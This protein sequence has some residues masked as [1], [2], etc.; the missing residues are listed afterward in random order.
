[1]KKVCKRCGE[2][3]ELKK[4]RYRPE[5][6]SGDGY[7]KTC[8][9]CWNKTRNKY[10]QE[11]KEQL[12]PIHKERKKKYALKNKEKINKTQREYYHNKFKITNKM[13]FIWRQILAT[14]LRR[15]NKKKSDK[16]IIMLGYSATQLK[17]HIECQFTSGMS[18]DNYGDW[19]ID[20]IKSVSSF[21][22]D[23]P[24]DVVNALSNLRPMWSTS[25]VIENV[26]YLGNL[27]KSKFDKLN[28]Q[29]NL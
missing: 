12:L 28:S 2:E 17:K 16:T 24:A 18:W 21:S 5:H 20:H 6:Y 15:M 1:M 14:C 3:K 23:I 8:T 26:F 4:F 19:H 7:A 11:N 9:D 27:N 29:K 25:R 10:Y 22:D 13:N